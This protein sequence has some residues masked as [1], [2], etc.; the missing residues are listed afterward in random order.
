MNVLERLDH[1]IRLTPEETMLVESVR[2]LAR[3]EIA[4]RAA[5]CDR[6]GDFPWDNI[7]AINGLGLNAMFVPE[8]YGGAQM[9]Y[10]A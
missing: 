9:S 7:R 8:R 5:E 10:V 1:G 2:A 4:S 6:T 3:N